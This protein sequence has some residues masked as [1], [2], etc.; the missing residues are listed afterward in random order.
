MFKFLCL[1]VSTQ[2]VWII[3]CYIL[4]RYFILFLP[5]FPYYW[6]IL[7]LSSTC[8]LKEGKYS[9][10]C[11]LFSFLYL[12]TFLGIS[13]ISIFS[14]KAISSLSLQVSQFFAPLFSRYLFIFYLFSPSIF[15]SFL[16]HSYDTSLSFSY[17]TRI[18]K[19]LAS[20]WISFL[21]SYENV[22]RKSSAGCWL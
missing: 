3:C 18:P 5:L 7:S 2:T 11:T 1:N 8:L 15:I 17:T 6:K 14:S 4:I 21:Y 12:I 20:T 13:I 10:L 19:C 22:G 16:R 9:F